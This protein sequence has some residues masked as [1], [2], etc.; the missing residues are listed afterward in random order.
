MDK[1]SKPKLLVILGPT[2][3]GKSGLAVALAQKFNGEVISADSRQVYKGLDIGTGKITKKEMGGIPHH[4]L[5]VS[6]P[7]KT[8]TVKNFKGLAEKA[9]EKILAKNKLPII[10]G[11]TG[12]YIQAV[13]DNISLPEVKPNQGLRKTLEKKSLDELLKTLQK[14]DP[15]FAKK[16]DKNNKR[17]LIRAIEIAKTLGKIPKIE[18]KP[19]YQTLEIG[20]KTD[21]ENLSKKI[22]E[23]L[24]K[25]IDDG[26]I[27]EAK[28]LH[29]SGLSWKKMDSLGLEYRF[30]AQF[31][32][33]KI[34]KEEMIKKL[35][36]AIWQYSRRQITWFKRDKRIKWFGI[37][38][39]KEIEKTILEFLS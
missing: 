21:K 4:L 38:Q 2:A 12:F 24:I 1:V 36:T 25:R 11:G 23:R 7:Q 28:N 3:S 5:D 8:F 18:S 14:L 27:K 16:I 31:L 20:I 22:Y 35:N 32:Q 19:K 30:L 15:E 9:V 26:M 10:C 33:N 17:K 13:V 37:N 39:K 29:K 34:T 6:S